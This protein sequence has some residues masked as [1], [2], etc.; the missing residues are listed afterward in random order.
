MKNKLIY[1]MIFMTTVLT[2]V[3]CKKYL[4]VN[5]DPNNPLE[6]SEN[7]ILSPIITDIGVT[8]AGGTFSNANTSGVA[9]IN[10][11]WM[12]QLSLNQPLP[13]Y[14]SY[15]FTTGDAEYTWGEMYINI[16][17]NLK[18]LKEAAEEHGNH[19]YGVIAKVLTAYT[20]GVTTD[21]WGDIPY[22]E[23]FEG[24]LHPAYDSQED[25]YNMIQQM[26]DDAIA[27]NQLDPGNLTPGADD[28]LYL[29]DMS[30][31]E[32]FAYALKARHYMH[33]T[34]APGHNAATQADLAL[35][36]L[37]NA[38]TGT[39]DEATLDIFSDAAG[40][41]S[42]WFKNTES[43]QGG[44]VL[45]STLID[46]LIARSDPRLPVI[47]NQGSLGTYLG[48]ESTSDVVPDVTIYSTLADHFSAAS[49]P[50]ALL[51]YS[52]LQFIKAE[53]TFIK[54]GA[55]AAQPIYQEAV[56]DNMVQLGLSLSDPDVVSYLA[57]RGPLTPANALQRIIEEKSIANLLAVEIF[58]DWRRTGFPTL[59]LVSNPQAG[60]TSIPR[61]YQYSQQEISTNPQPQNTDI[62]IT[63]RVWWDTQ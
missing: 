52:E 48:R 61:R 37:E 43:S 38:F 5:T 57:S 11:Y 42:P 15:K 10:S 32:K 16:M 35:T 55:A 28:F 12:Q 18:R 9:L 14:E 34:K 50:I 46:G 27:E 29:G 33:L 63:D 19:S 47:A 30:K 17:Q 7:L 22:T 2:T 62:N 60:V 56:K 40:H 49:A 36:A 31:W 8:V 6:A 59:S 20:L 53:A 45:G 54:S 13:Q 51:P 4:D 26:L 41:E 1:G 21:M 58:N 44:V 23:A 25:I 3:S 24:N 39:D